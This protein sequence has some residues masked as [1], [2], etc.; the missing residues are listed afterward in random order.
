MCAQHTPLKKRW[1]STPALYA[2]MIFLGVISGY[3]D[4]AFLK[5]FGL[6]I[7]DI[8]IKIFKCISLPIIALSIIVTL[9]NYRADGVMRTVWRRA[10]SYTLGTTL[11][12]AAI[13]CL[14]YLLIHPGMMGVIKQGA[15][16]PQTA[17]LSYLQHIANLI[18]STILEPFI[19]HQVMGVLLIGIVVG[20]AIRFIPEA[21]ARQTITQFFRGA[22]GLFMVV[23][24][25]VI[26][27]IPLGLY[28]FITSTVV[29]LREG[30][31]IKGIGEYLLIIVL[32]NLIQ[33]LVILPLWLK[34][35][36]IKPFVAF[37]GMLPALSVAFFSKSSVG[38]LPVTMETAEKNLKVKPEISRFVLPLCTSLNMNGCAA[39]IFT[40]VIYLMQNHGIEISLPMMGLWVIIATIAAIGNAG[41]P[42]GCFFLSASLLA[43][44]NVPITLMGIILPFYSLIDMLE[45]A[46]NVWSD[47]CVAKVVNEKVN[48]E[49]EAGLPV[50]GQLQAEGMAN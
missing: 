35:Q 49:G 45:T 26:A 10:M 5:S 16:G 20:V 4:I 24:N 29:Q 15:I 48:Q 47:S 21:E 9:S 36:G 41:V 50:Q 12:A 37:K 39:F 23:T 46:L 25:W 7:S 3:S 34:S 22:H 43:S 42:M 2:A 14:L 40:T 17:Q 38:T 8:F 19:Q 13:S 11:V 30:M 28:G 32:A 27:V 6:L 31:A 18:P 33:G 44:M 1:F